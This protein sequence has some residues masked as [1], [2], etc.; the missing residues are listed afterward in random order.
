MSVVTG[1]CYSSGWHFHTPFAISLED[2]LIQRQVVDLPQT[3]ASLSGK[4][5]VFLSMKMTYSLNSAAAPEIYE[6]YGENYIDTLMP[7]DEI[8][9]VIKPVTAKYTIDEFA[10]SRA[11]YQP[12]LRGIPVVM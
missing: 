8:F 12:L 2:M 5:T 6:N 7:T 11:S 4:E 10:T 3:S 9:D 1:K